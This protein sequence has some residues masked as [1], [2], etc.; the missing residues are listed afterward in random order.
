M[1]RE[2][3][4]R[5]W[6]DERTKEGKGREGKDKEERESWIRTGEGWEMKG[7]GGGERGM[8]D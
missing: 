4:G 8:G 6:R 7:R 3:K 5:Q 2:G 1:G